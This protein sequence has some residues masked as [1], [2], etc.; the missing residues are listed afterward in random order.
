MT[1]V[2]DWIASPVGVCSSYAT[3]APPSARTILRPTT[4]DPGPEGIL[5]VLKVSTFHLIHPHFLVFDSRVVPDPDY[6]PPTFL[7]LY[8]RSS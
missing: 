1:L 2:A 4:H 7:S 3:L 6:A 8:L 5:A